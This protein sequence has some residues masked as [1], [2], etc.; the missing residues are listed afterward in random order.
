MVCEDEWGS[1]QMNP[2]NHL[3]FS[4]LR[5]FID[6]HFSIFPSNFIEV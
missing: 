2:P 4:L 1:S 3:I 6:P 5:D